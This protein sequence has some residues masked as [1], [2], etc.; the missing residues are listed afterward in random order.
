MKRNR[1]F[2][3][4]ELLV[5]IAIIAILASLLLP[6][7]KQARE[8]AKS[9]LCMSN[10]KQLGL[11]CSFYSLDFDGSYPPLQYN[12]PNIVP[13]TAL[14]HHQDYN[15]IQSHDLFTCPSM[16]SDSNIHARTKTYPM[17]NASWYYSNYGMNRFYRAQRI[18]RISKPSEA[19]FLLDTYNAG[20]RTRGLYFA[21]HVFTAGGFQGQVHA[22][23]ASS[24]NVLWFDLHITSQ[25]VGCGSDASLYNEGLNAYR[26]EPFSNGTSSTL[27]HWDRFNN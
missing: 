13:W 19:L 9:V 5:V 26:E 3:L 25:K 2:T 6:A 7:L 20:L 21:L 16:K 15:Y 4:I 18:A 11:G 10:L 27:G 22:R 1:A 24:A 12:T 8:K 14:L 23:H 17:D